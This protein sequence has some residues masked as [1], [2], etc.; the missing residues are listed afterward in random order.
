MENQVVVIQRNDDFENIT[1]SSLQEV[2]PWL[3][4]QFIYDF[5]SDGYGAILKKSVKS[6]R[7]N[8]DDKFYNK[9]CESIGFTKKLKPF[10]RNSSAS[11]FEKLCKNQKP[12]LIECDKTG[13][14]PVSVGFIVK[15][16]ENMLVL[17]YFDR[18]GKFKSPNRKIMIDDV[19][20]V[21]FGNKYLNVYENI[22]NGKIS[23]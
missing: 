7:N 20:I 10:L 9:I 1:A 19:S 16:D 21:K 8:K 5:D 15:H 11:L 17:K 18:M 2:G 6:I 13:E 22:M 14:W 3:I 4:F 12:V 23:V